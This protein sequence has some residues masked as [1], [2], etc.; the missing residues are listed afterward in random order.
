MGMKAYAI[1]TAFNAGILSPHV[2]LGRVDLQKYGSGVE[3]MLNM[4]VHSQGPA[5]RR[6]GTRFVHEAKYPDREVRLIPFRFNTEQ[7]YVLEFGHNYMRVLK[8]GGIVVTP[9][10]ELI[11]NGGFDADTANWTALNSALLSSVA[12]GKSGNGLE[13]KEGGADEP[14]FSQSVAVDEG[15]S[16]ALELAVKKGTVNEFKV[17]LWDET[18]DAAIFT[19]AWITEDGEDFA[20]Y[21]QPFVAPAGCASVSVRI[22]SRAASGSGYALYFD[23]VS[24]VETDVIYEIE[25]PYTEDEV[26]DLRFTQSADV[27]YIVHKAYNPQKLTRTGHASWTLETVTFTSKP[28]DWNDT[29]GYPTVVA[30]HEEKL[31]FAATP[32]RPQTIWMSKSSDYEN[33]GVSSPLVDDDAVTHT[34]SA[35]Q[36]NEIRWIKSARRLLI[37]TAG[38]EWW[39]NGGSDKEPITPIN[40]MARRETAWGSHSVEACSI[41]DMTLFVQRDGYTIREQGYAL[42]KDGYA[43]PDISVLARNLFEGRQVRNWAYQQSPDSIVWMCMSEGSLVG[44]TYFRE[45]EVVGFHRHDLGGSGKVESLCSIPGSSLDELWMVVRREING[46]TVRYIERLDP[47]FTG[48]DAKSAF[49]VDSGLSY[50]GEPTATLTGLDHLEGQTVQVLADGSTHDSLTVTNGGVTLNTPAS[51]VHVGLGYVSDLKTLPI[52][53]PTPIGTAQ[54]RTKRVSEISVRLHRSLGLKVGENEGD[55]QDENF[56]TTSTVAG[57][58]PDLFSGNWEVKMVGAYGPDGQFLLRQAY[59]LPLTVAAIISKVEVS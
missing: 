12:G 1:Q 16:Y 4:I 13:L 8:D 35:D 6:S 48:S 52:D 59:P 17:Q 10:P 3:D 31:C 25:T 55:L 53:I 23:A 37:G 15:T 49:F 32:A 36:V 29:K 44:L 9:G 19:T 42:D 38:G 27:M 30:F 18:N 41:G 39:I 57:Q 54:G 40:R 56:T 5:S 51:V 7:A 24:V 20:V 43:A 26:H 50:E 45:H 21:E 47:A 11:T 33:F 22:Y 46:N 14:G 58:P 34:L 2:Y 28:S